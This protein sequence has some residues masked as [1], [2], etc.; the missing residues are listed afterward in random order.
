MQDA[1]GE[2]RARVPGQPRSGFIDR[3]NG[4]VEIPGH[5]FHG[6]N[7]EPRFR[8]LLLLFAGNERNRVHTGAI[9]DLVI[10][11]ACQQTQRQT[12]TPE[13]WASIRSI[14]RWVITAIFANERAPRGV[15][16]V[17]GPPKPA[18]PIWRSSDARPFSGVIGLPLRLLAREV[19]NKIVDRAGGTR[20]RSLPA[21]RDKAAESAV[22]GFHRGSDARIRVSFLA[23]DEI[24]IAADLERGHVFT[25]RILHRRGRDE[26]LLL[27]AATMRR[28]SS[29]YCPAPASVERPR[30]SQLEF[31]GDRK[32][33]GSRGAPRSWRFRLMKFTPLPN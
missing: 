23:V 21:K 15:T 6:G 18:R 26:T 2:R 16:A 1:I 17:L 20:L 5:R 11:L 25:D 24:Q 14:A 27:G 30:L 9:D 7:P 19:Y 8:R 29:D 33:R 4:H 12:I 3:R 32:S 31:A 13:E 22:L 10:D 28:S